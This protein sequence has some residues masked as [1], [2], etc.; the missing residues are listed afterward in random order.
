MAN[1]GTIATM[2][3]DDV[4][5][6]HDLRN[7]MAIASRYLNLRAVENMTNTLTMDSLVGNASIPITMPPDTMYNDNDSLYNDRVGDDS[8][9]EDGVEEV[10]EKSWE[11]KHCL[12]LAC[13]VNFG[14]SNLRKI[15]LTGT[16]ILTQP[17][18]RVL[19]CLSFIVHL[20]LAHFHAFKLTTMDL[21][22]LERVSQLK[23]IRQ[24]KVFPVIRNNNYRAAM[25]DA[26]AV[27]TFITQIGSTA[28]T[29]GIKYEI[30]EVEEQMEW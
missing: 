29:L 11:Y 4:N 26:C 27:A 3:T 13:A 23:M 28:L 20:E 21:N 7:T 16:S 24:L 14:P 1:I 17:L 12:W 6:E 8:K 9:I 10:V 5:P 2:T 25:Y 15:R 30:I 19:S 18:I 22:G